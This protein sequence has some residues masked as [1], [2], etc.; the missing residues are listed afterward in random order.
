MRWFALLLTGCSFQ[1][2]LA[3]DVRPIDAANDSM[4]ID[5]STT[6]DTPGPAVITFIQG[7]AAS[8]SSN[9]VGIM[10]NVPIVDGDLCVLGVG[11]NGG[12]ISSVG[13]TGNNTFNSAGSGGGQ[14][15]YVAA[16]MHAGA[17]DRITVTFNGSTGYTF[18]VAIYRGLAKASPIDATASASGNSASFDS[19][20]ASTSHAHDLLVGVAA[21][22]GAMLPGT[23]YS[24]HAGGT[25]S[26]IEDREV[27]ATGS[28]HATVTAASNEQWA[29]RL[30]AL[31]AND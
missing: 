11:T 31:K 7:T 2:R 26:L 21:S 29:L 10:L 3:S 8:G 13:D 18:A 27:T 16:N 5:A 20:A 24:T 19:G 6:I 30:I 17:S 9:Q 14:T 28:Y 23:N 12:S 4:L 1:A 25:F 15:V 22:D